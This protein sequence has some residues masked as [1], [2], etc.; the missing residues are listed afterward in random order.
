MAKAETILDIVALSDKRDVPAKDLT[1]L[2]LKRLELARGLSSDPKVLLIDEVAAGLTEM[3]IPSFLE[4]LKKIRSLGITYIMIEHVL[5]VMVEAV[6]R[7]TVLDSGMKI[8]EGS[9][10]EIMEDEKV[11]NAYLG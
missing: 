6:D 7:I 10:R 1:A 2:T 9:P 8:A 11:I 5:K 4:I 3:E